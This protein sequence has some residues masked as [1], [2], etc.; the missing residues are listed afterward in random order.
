MAPLCIIGSK[1]CLR[2]R[3]LGFRRQGAA[4]P[5]EV[6][7]ELVAQEGLAPPGQAD[8]D[9]DQ[10]LAVQRARAAARPSCWRGGCRR[11]RSRACRCCLRACPAADL[12]FQGVCVGNPLNPITRA[13]ARAR[14]RPA[15]LLAGRLPPAALAS[16]SLLPARMPCYLRPRGYA[17]ALSTLGQ[18]SCWG[19]RLIWRGVRA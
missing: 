10:L 2:F 6:A 16:V 3:V 14:R 17:I 15:F 19:V 5:V 9:D 13:R 11:P 4:A 8:Q 1:L 7:H 12:G 18:S